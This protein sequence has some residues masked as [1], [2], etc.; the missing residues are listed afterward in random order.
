MLPTVVASPAAYTF[1]TEVCF[2]AST[3]IR[4]PSGLSANVQPSRCTSGV[5]I[6][7]VAG[8]N[9][10]RCA[11]RRPSASS[12]SS[13]LGWSPCTPITGEVSICTPRCCM[14]ARSASVIG[15]PWLKKVT[16][17]QSANSG[18]LAADIGWPPSRPIAPPPT[19]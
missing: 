19:S 6:A 10:A 13:Q 16:L 3:S 8:T 4:T 5:A 7:W 18:A 1:G 11:T 17:P 12:T 14:A 9:S 2:I 15:R